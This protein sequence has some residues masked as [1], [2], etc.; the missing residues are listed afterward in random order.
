[1]ANPTNKVE[2]F[3]RVLIDLTGDSVSSD[4]L[5]V[6]ETAHDKSGAEIVGTIPKQE[7][8]TITPGEQEQIA[9]LAGTY[10]IGDIK[11]GP[12]GSSLESW[13]FTLE[14]GSTV[15]KLVGPIPVTYETWTFTNTDNT[16]MTR[17]VEVSE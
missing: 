7:G 11:V 1:M 15:T 10:V 6:G 2:Y 14:D 5:L 8:T 4:K 9:V 13:T 16:T 12:A 3:G 17:E